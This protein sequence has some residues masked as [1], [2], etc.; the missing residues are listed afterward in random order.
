MKQA[1]LFVPSSNH[2]GFDGALWTRATSV[3]DGDVQILELLAVELNVDRSVLVRLSDGFVKADRPPGHDLGPYARLFDQD[4]IEHQDRRVYPLRHAFAKIAVPT[5]MR[6]FDLS[7]HMQFSGFGWHGIDPCGPFP[8]FHDRP[9]ISWEEAA[10]Y[11][12]VSIKG[13]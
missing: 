9:P 3:D 12:E 5:G 6:E 10:N 4:Q 13:N 8:L 2:A 7:N 1:Q 11:A